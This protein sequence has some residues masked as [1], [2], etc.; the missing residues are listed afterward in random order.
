MALN[1]SYF[2]QYFSRVFILHSPMTISNLTHAP[3]NFYIPFS[4]LIG[5]P[6]DLNK[7]AEKSSLYLALPNLQSYVPLLLMMVISFVQ[8]QLLLHSKSSPSEFNVL[9]CLSC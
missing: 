1:L 6:L 8:G 2:Q 3:Q 9:K 4:P 7:P 5:L